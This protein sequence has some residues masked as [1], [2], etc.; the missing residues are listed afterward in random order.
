[1]NETLKRKRLPPHP[2]PFITS[3]YP[4]PFFPSLT[5]FPSLPLYLSDQFSST[6]TLTQICLTPPPPRYLLWPS[7]PSLPRPGGGCC[8]GCGAGAD[9][10]SR[11][12][13]RRLRRG[14]ARRWRRSAIHN[15][16]HALGIRH[17][18]HAALGHQQWGSLRGACLACPGH[19]SCTLT[20][21]TCIPWFYIWIWTLHL[22]V[23]LIH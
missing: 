7:F 5:L 8:G 4:P 23:F 13:P 14:D 16:P 9:V 1:M 18:G 15:W 2:V 22:N 17:A 3:L 6:S 10:A 19:T 20:S 21:I 11:R 12:R